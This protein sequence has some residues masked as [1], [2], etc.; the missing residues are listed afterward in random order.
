LEDFLDPIYEHVGVRYL[1]HHGHS[2]TGQS[3]MQIAEIM[4]LSVY[5]HLACHGSLKL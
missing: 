5:P 4:I 1:N 2:F 3:F